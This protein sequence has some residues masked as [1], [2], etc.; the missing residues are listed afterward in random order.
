MLIVLD[1]AATTH[2]VTSSCGSFVANG[3]RLRLRYIYDVSTAV[4]L[5]HGC[6]DGGATG[7]STTVFAAK[8]LWMQYASQQTCVTTPDFRLYSEDSLTL[9]LQVPSHKGYNI[10]VAYRFALVFGT[11]ARYYYL[12]CNAFIGCISIVR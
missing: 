8:I 11:P 7:S 6:S 2:Y 1:H 9:P 5:L 10:G 4:C 12:Y 3:K